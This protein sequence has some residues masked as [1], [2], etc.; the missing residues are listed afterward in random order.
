MAS[1]GGRLAVVVVW[2]GLR[3]DFVSAEVT[4]TL[5][6]LANEGVWCEASHCAYPSETRVNSSALATGCYPG[7]TGITGNSFF[8]RGFDP[9]HPAG[10][11][12]TGDHTQLARLAEL[13]PPL[14]RAQTVADAVRAA[15][16][17]MV[18][19]SSGSP[20][21]ALLQ[22]PSAEAITANIALLRPAWLAERVVRDY[23]AVPQDSRPATGRSD[24]MTRALLEILLTE[25]VRP[26]VLDGKPA[27]AHWWLTD[28][29]HTAHHDGLG[30]PTTVQSL[31]ENDRRLAELERRLIELGLAERTDVFLT[32]DHGFS[33]AGPPRG[34]DKALVEAGLREAADSDDVV[35]TGQGG[36]AITLHERAHRRAADVVRWLQEQPWVGPVFVRD[37]G[38]ADGLPG[39]LP[40][41]IAWNGR[42]GP[43]SPDIKFSAGWSDEA[44]PFGIV[45]SVLAGGGRGASHG[46]ASPHDMRNSLFAWGPSFQREL[47]S[48]VPAGIVDV[49]PTVRQLLGLPAVETD[50]RVLQELLVGGPDPSKMGQAT[51]THDAEVSWPGGAYRQ[52]AVV[53]KVGGTSYLDRVDAEHG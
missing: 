17:V 21:S 45:G 32:A 42:V 2:D 8:V 46:S 29:D 36:G 5:W 35:T 50:G 14:L 44:G 27:M 49:A 52:R 39:T 53:S 13:D 31:R 40:L 7:R 11:V 4:P 20:G 3:P 6:R 19:A 10:L 22:D 1:D 25:V 18:V 51:E 48:S 12:N 43:R 33:T 30:A 38:P 41:S 16:G 28:P 26:V 34:F 37:G 47:R 23:G 24:W 9:Q 15:G